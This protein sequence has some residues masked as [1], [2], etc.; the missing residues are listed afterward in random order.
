VNPITIRQQQTLDFIQK[1]IAEKGY[2]PSMREIGEGVNSLSPSTILAIIGKLEDKGFITRQNN[3]PRSIRIVGQGDPMDALIESQKE[4]I[5]GY[6]VDSEL[7]L[8]DI[9]KLRSWL[10]NAEAKEANY[11]NLRCGFDLAVKAL[12]DIKQM[13]DMDHSSYQKYLIWKKAF[14]ALEEIK[15]TQP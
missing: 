6:K 3:V 7:R 1:F 5:E 14:D 12:Q 11:D 8:A 10:K 2:S 15:G 4:E 13:L 9:D